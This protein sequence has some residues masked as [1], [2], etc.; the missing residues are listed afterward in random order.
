[1][2]PAQGLTTGQPVGTGQLHPSYRESREPQSRHVEPMTR[3]SADRARSPRGNPRTDEPSRQIHNPDGTAR[4]KRP[5]TQ[6]ETATKG[7]DASHRSQSQRRR[8]ADI[9]G[10]PP[11]RG[12][13]AS[14]GKM[15]RPV[16]R[17]AR[18]AAREAPSRP[19]EGPPTSTAPSSSCRMTGGVSGRWRY[20]RSQITK[21]PRHRA[22]WRGAIACLTRHA[23]S[24]G[25]RRP[26][27]NPRGH[28]RG[29]TRGGRAARR[30]ET[31]AD[32]EGDARGRRTERHAVP[33]YARGPRHHP[34][35]GAR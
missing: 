4:G 5:S 15:T 25:A 14:R 29:G 32:G 6:G 31:S 27:T 28:D 13:V 10:S 24:L 26:G 12:L 8:G 35:D 7:G 30:E 11:V 17:E 34:G 16:P 22:G 3:G 33:P 19:E 9:V 2:S 20:T 23:A 21:T 1:M 18:R